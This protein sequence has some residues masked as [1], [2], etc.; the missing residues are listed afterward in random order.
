V[1]DSFQEEKKSIIEI[2]HLDFTYLEGQK[3]IENFNLTIFDQ[4]LITI[5]GASGCGKSTLL[6]I[7]AGLL[8]PSSGR[9]LI[10]G[11]VI[12]GPGPDRTMVFQDDAVFP[13]YSTAECGIWPAVQ[14]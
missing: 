3:V 7:L 5:V 4:E 1:A 14:K 6:N 8:P 13:W 2:E 11:K 9:A 10:N 12:T